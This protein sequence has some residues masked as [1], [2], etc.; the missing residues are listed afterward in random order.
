MFYS[1]IFLLVLTVKKEVHT[2]IVEERQL[3]YLEL[4]IFSILAGFQRSDVVCD[5]P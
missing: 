4:P 5:L 1:V 3:D 2:Y